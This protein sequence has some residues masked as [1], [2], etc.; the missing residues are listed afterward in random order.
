MREDNA[1]KTAA[2]NEQGRFV[3]QI[4]SYSSIILAFLFLMLSGREYGIDSK[5]FIVVSGMIVAALALQP[6]P[7]R[8][9]WRR[10]S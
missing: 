10:R 9:F 1:K 7:G 4:I 8:S 3:G 6:Y 2:L 5:E